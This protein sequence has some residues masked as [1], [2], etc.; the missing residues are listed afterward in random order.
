[1]S[2]GLDLQL[3]HGFAI[4]E[5]SFSTSTPLEIITFPTPTRTSE[6]SLAYVLLVIYTLQT[7]PSSPNGDNTLTG[8]V[9]ATRHV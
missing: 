8:V 9:V 6:Y 3:S 2:S 7:G 5:R 1:M 4:S